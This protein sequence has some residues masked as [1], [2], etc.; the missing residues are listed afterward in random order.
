MSVLV[1]MQDCSKYKGNGTGI[2]TSAPHAP[3]G[4]IGGS[5]APAARL[6]YHCGGGL[7]LNVLLSFAQFE[8]EIRGEM[9]D[10]LAQAWTAATAAA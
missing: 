9:V 4:A 2:N 1:F 7:T 3:T 8:R 5:E 6:P 10:K